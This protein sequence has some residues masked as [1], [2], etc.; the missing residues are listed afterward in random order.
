MPLLTWRGEEGLRAELSAVTF[1]TAVAKTAAALADWEVP[2]G[3]TVRLDLPLHWQLPVWL[4]ACDL[5]GATVVTEGPA[6]VVAG[7]DADRLR[8]AEAPWPVLVSTHPL[9]LPGPPA[10]A[11]L[12]DHARDAMGQ[13]DT[14]LEMPAP[15]STWVTP[16]GTWQR[17]DIVAAARRSA[18]GDNL[19]SAGRL[20]V[21]RQAPIP[22]RWLGVWAEPLV[23]GGSAVLCDTDDCDQVAVAEHVTAFQEP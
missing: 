8:V 16:A 4:G 6:D 14:Y 12:F 23:T 17:S 18:A 13:P 11:P 7:T 10:P 1:L 19:T 15:D 5:S 9:G 20:L 3:A 22:A 2:P 21:S